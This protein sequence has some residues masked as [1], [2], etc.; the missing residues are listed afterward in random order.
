MTVL[1]TDIYAA[2]RDSVRFYPAQEL[3][4]NQPQT[5][6]VL[7]RSGAVEIST[8]NLGATICDKD[9]PFFWSRLWHEKGYNPNNI[10]WAFP[11]LYAA[12]VDSNVMVDPFGGAPKF[13]Y[14]IQVGILD[15]WTDDPDGRKC[16]GCNARTINEIYFDTQTVLQS[17]LKYLENTR[18]Y[19]ID[20]GP[21][22]WANMDFVAQAL[23]AQRIVSA[24]FK[25]PS[26]LTAS[27]SLNREAPFFR[28]ERSAEKIYG[29]AIN[30]RF[31]ASGC[32]TP[33][34]NFTETDFGVLAQEAG[35]KTC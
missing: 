23:A 4:C 18:G 24:D 6:R 12:E 31:A 28:V 16:V 20:A 26:I 25:A 8:A 19:S 32:I 34:W 13:I 1:L 27:Q 33:E 17:C 10:T 14:N 5:W 15:V 7:Q 30:L 9:K 22:V 21:D 11:L 35:C 29:T 3:K 2:L